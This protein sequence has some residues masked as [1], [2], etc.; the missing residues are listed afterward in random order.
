M[1]KRLRIVDGMSFTKNMKVA[2]GIHHTTGKAWAEI[3]H[4]TL[5]LVTQWG[6]TESEAVAKA[7]EYIARHA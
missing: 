4:R 5:G 3:K 1:R 7:K 6:Q 2:S